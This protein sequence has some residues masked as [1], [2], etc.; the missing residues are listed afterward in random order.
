MLARVLRDFRARHR[1][2]EQILERHFAL[3]AHHAAGT[4][5]SRERRL[6]IGAYFTHEY[7]VEAAALF[8]PSHRAGARPERGSLP[9]SAGS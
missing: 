8:N 3:V 7:S 2:F 5:L 1:D 9:A 6:L 4:A